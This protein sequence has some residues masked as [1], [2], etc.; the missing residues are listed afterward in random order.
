M[1]RLTD[2]EQAMRAGR[3]EL[4]EQAR[5]TQPRCYAARVGD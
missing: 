3:F 1:T 4:I 2:E 5:Q